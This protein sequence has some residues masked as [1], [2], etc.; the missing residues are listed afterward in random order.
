M[1]LK[2]PRSITPGINRGR[3]RLR[4]WP[5]IIF[6]GVFAYYY[7]S[8]KQI[9]PET[10]RTQL[11]AVSEEQLKPLAFH[12]YQKILAQSQ[13]LDT[14]E[15]V[16]YVRGIAAKIIRVVNRQNLEWE[17]NIIDS[18][19]ANAF[20]LP[21]GKI[22]IYTGILPV[23]KNADGLA[24]V[25]AHEI[26]HVTAR[27][28]AERM[29]HQKLVQFGTIAASM[30]VG[31]MDYDTQRMV[32][33]AIGVGSQFGFVLPYSRVHESEADQIGLTYLAMACFDPLEAPLLWQRMAELSN[34]NQVSE[35]MSTHPAPETRIKQL[36][37]LIP[38]ALKIRDKHCKIK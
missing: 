4:I 21:G 14:G 29:T 25:I 13:V 22:A 37:K 9:V 26:A 5:V 11:V 1:R 20:A 2:L 33:G 8:S 12:S 31:E 30:A 38:E 6:A 3:G 19:Q 16:E 7:F 32:M 36:K 10:G 35:L 28:G 24:T 23:A 27:H 15:E 34:R 17:V 18:P